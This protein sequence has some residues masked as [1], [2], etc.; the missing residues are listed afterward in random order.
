MLTTSCELRF[1]Q[2]FGKENSGSTVLVG[3]ASVTS[4]KNLPP[5]I[6]RL[7]FSKRPEVRAGS[8]L[9]THLDRLIRGLDRLFA[10]PK[11]EEEQSRRS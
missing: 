5:E 6:E 3:K 4:A 8:D 10:V 7:A 11:A 2:H 1:K 9:Q